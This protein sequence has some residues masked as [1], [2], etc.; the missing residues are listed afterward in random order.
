M[1]KI[2]K[3]AL[4]RCRVF[5]C[6]TLDPQYLMDHLIQEGIMTDDMKDHI[7]GE[8]TRL[9]R[10]ES[11]LDFIPTRGPTAFDAFMG[12]LEKDYGFVI[13]KIYEKIN[14]LQQQ[15][16]RRPNQPPGG[17]VANNAHISSNPGTRGPGSTLPP[18]QVPPYPGGGQMTSDPMA[19]DARR[20]V[21][22][23]RQSFDAVPTNWVERLPNEVKLRPVTEAELFHIAHHIGN[24]W[25]MLAAQMGFSRGEIDHFR[26]YCQFDQSL[27]AARM[28]S[29]WRSKE[30]GNATV[31]N[32]IKLLQISYVDESVYRDVFCS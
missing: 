9:R 24:K 20:P 10:I 1:E 15:Q 6:E 14:E 7:M 16:Q 32:L 29:T 12:S 28:L 31:I 18:H 5:L 27:Q 25:E 2:H 21:Q 4:I 13:E 17:A 22:E 8:R 26:M 19:G 23:T 30:S 11:L 3:D